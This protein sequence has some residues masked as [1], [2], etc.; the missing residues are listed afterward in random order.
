MFI[1]DCV[2][3][4]FIKNALASS[5]ILSHKVLMALI[6]ADNKVHEHTNLIPQAFVVFLVT[7]LHD[8]V[9]LR[10]EARNG[11]RVASQ[12]GDC[13]LATDFDQVPH[14]FDCERNDVRSKVLSIVD[15]ADEVTT[16]IHFNDLLSDGL[17][18]ADSGKSLKNT[19]HSVSA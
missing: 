11:L 2:V 17:V 16:N 7:F 8:L 4:D 6:R 9:E 14:S 3:N 18:V 19:D 5:P 10:L 12:V 15:Y 13:D 1:I